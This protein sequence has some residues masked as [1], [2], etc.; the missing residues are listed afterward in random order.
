MAFKKQTTTIRGGYCYDHA[1]PR[2]RNTHS[3]SKEQVNGSTSTQRGSAQE[4][5]TIKQA[6]EKHLSDSLPRQQ[7]NESSSQAQTLREQKILKPREGR[8][9]S[10][11][12]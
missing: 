12:R 10:E 7:N 4:Q 11:Y 9:R 1:T 2:D 8:V 5:S 3:F 6:P